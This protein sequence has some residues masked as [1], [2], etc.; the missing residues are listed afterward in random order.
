MNLG[1]Q[2]CFIACMCSLSIF[3]P[4][5]LATQHLYAS[6]ILVEIYSARQRQYNTK[7]AQALVP[8]PRSHLAVDLQ[9]RPEVRRQASGALA[10]IPHSGG[11][12]LDEFSISIGAADLS[13]TRISPGAMSISRSTAGARVKIT[14][15]RS[16]ATFLRNDRRRSDR[17]ILKTWTGLS[18]SGE[19]RSRRDARLHHA[20]PNRPSRM[21]ADLDQTKGSRNKRSSE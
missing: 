10:P 21:R 12:E 11:I 7:K 8:T 17:G 6:L 20:R 19:R 5:V 16:E 9:L 4:F 15:S 1:K 14:A 3:I 2:S 18:T 13:T